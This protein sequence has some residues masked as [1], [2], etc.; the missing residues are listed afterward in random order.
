MAITLS[1]PIRTAVNWDSSIK[2]LTVKK[3]STWKPKNNSSRHD[4][5][6]RIKSLGNMPKSDA[7]RSMH[8]SETIIA[9]GNDIVRRRNQNLISIANRVTFEIQDIT[10]S[11]GI[12]KM[13][14]IARDCNDSKNAASRSARISDEFGNI[15]TERC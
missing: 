2:T 14:A 4:D 1:M 7:T 15:S 10:K 11:K 8:E 5:I 13:S 6:P 9:F 12:V 3:Q